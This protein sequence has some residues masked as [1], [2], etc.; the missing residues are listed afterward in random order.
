MRV[1]VVT[2]AVVTAACARAAHEASR[3]YCI[4]LDDLSQPSWEDAP[5]WQRSS[6][7]KGV[8]LALRGAT[9]EESHIS[10]LAEKTRTGWAYGP[11]KDAEAK[12]HP[13]MVPY[14]D[15]PP[16]QRAKDALYLASVRAM[17]AALSSVD[18]P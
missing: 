14:A 7:I 6:A 3:T 15:L 13:C 10:W 5:E 8:E 11:L 2:A 18:R 12:T 16:A 17:A 9:P 1:A 4:A